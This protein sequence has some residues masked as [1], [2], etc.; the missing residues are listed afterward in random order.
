[1]QPGCQFDCSAHVVQMVSRAEQNQA[2]GAE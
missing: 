1:V 2:T